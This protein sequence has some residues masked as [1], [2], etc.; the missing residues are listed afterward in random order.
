[1][2]TELARPTLQVGGALFFWAMY[3]ERPSDAEL[4][5]LLGRGEYANVFCSRQMGKT[6]LLHRTRRRLLDK[7]VKVAL[8]DVAGYLGKP[9]NAD[10]WYRGLLE[11]IAESLDLEVNVQQWWLSC[12]VATPN[13]RLIRFFRDEVATNAGAP[14]V[15]FLDE[16]D[17][18]LRLPY[19]DDFFVAI[20]AMYN[21]RP[22]EPAFEKIAFCLVGVVTPNELIKDRRTTPY[23]I[24]RTLELS[25][26]DAGR[27]DLGPLYRALANDPQ[28]GERLAQAVLRWT[29]GHPYLT[30]KLC[31]DL[32]KQRATI[33]DA[34]ER[35]I[36]QLFP[37]LQGARSDVHFETVLRFFDERV[38]DRLTAL[39][40]YGRIHQG[41]L[42]PDRTNPVHIALKLSG[43]VKRNEIGLLVVRNPIYRRV[44]TAEWARRA[45]PSARRRVRAAWRLA[46]ASV[47]LF[48]LGTLTWYEGIYPWQLTYRLNQAIIEDRYAVD[49][50]RMLR[51]VPFYTG[52]A[53]RLRAEF[54]DRRALRAE[55]HE[56]RG[57]ALLWRLKALSIRP[58]DRR[59]REAALFIGEDYSRLAGTFHHPD[60]LDVAISAD[61]RTLATGGRDGT[62]RLWGTASGEPIGPSL[63]H[64][65][66]VWSVALSDDGRTLA[67]GGGDGRARLWRVPSGEPIGAPLRHGNQVISVALSGDGQ[68]L[69]TAGGDG[70]ARLWRMTSDLPIGS[71][72]PQQE[73]VTSVAL[74]GDGRI[75]A[76]GDDGAARLWRVPDG[77]PIGPPLRAGGSIGCV[78]LSGDGRMLATRGS[79]GTARLWHVPSGKPIGL[80]LPPGDRVI[81]VALSGDG[82][83]LATGG[84]DGMA[85]LWRVS[86][87]APPPPGV[88]VRS[89]A[90]SGDGRTLATVSSDGMAQLWHVSN[91]APTGAPIK[92]GGAVWSLAL[93]SDGR[94]LATA[95]ADGTARL[96]HMPDGEPL[97][98]PIKP[99][100]AVWSLALSGDGRTLA[101]GTSLGT[102][103]LWRVSDGTPIGTP[104]LPGGS[105]S[106]VA[107]SDDGRTLAI[108]SLE[109]TVRMWHAS[110]GKPMGE[111]LHYGKEVGS[112]ALSP[113]GRMVLTATKT[114]IHIARFDGRDLTH[115]ASRLSPRMW[116]NRD[117]ARFLDDSGMHVQVVDWASIGP[118][119]LLTV[120]FD[121]PG[122]QPVRGD[123]TALLQE[124]ERKMD[125][126]ITENGEIVPKH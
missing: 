49:T 79:D 13:Q 52:R 48:A 46:V 116:P 114:W 22:Q 62:A 47:A 110:S 120:R 12:P 6:S 100:G 102:V 104:L 34:V 83:M 5:E 29:C 60:L 53:D 122:A 1:M 19:T 71:P 86:G 27:D 32:L 76:T 64:G 112:L 25:D 93:S 103:R 117:G 41:R 72:L 54:F 40:L 44:F 9:G 89:V 37:N 38:G 84:R 105:V 75:L 63:F 42:E 111:S 2:S 87:D 17:S 69:A 4:P 33:P 24:G 94:M 115:V 66:V 99:G 20:R 74:S 21:D 109:G 18:T 77:K 39:M 113:D 124:W 43:I 97:A 70:A 68:L 26:F 55:Q 92:P 51:S 81:S 126:R 73:S 10:D 16:I 88:T 45:M 36:D 90:L 101:T 119:R 35:Q 11:G 50:F 98:A 106:S 82:R 85:R 125:V 23:N 95:S 57:Q 28:V 80:P 14:I 58:T 30:L 65:D 108:G 123:P 56:E 118:S 31:E 107:L 67:T 59:A 96:L 121:Q 61:G 15:I 3:I 78:A 91:G 8:I 7:G